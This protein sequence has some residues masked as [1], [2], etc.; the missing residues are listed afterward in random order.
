MDRTTWDSVNNLTDQD[1]RD[2]WD[3]TTRN[4]HEHFLALGGRDR[5]DRSRLD[6]VSFPSVILFFFSGP[7]GKMSCQKRKKKKIK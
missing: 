1:S 5:F 6:R 4:P 7:S 2:N 3:K